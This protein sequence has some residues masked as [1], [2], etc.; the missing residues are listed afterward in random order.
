MCCSL[1]FVQKNNAHT[2]PDRHIWDDSGMKC[3]FGVSYILSMSFYWVIIVHIISDPVR[4]TTIQYIISPFSIVKRKQIFIL[5]FYQSTW[6]SCS[7]Q[8]VCRSALEKISPEKKYINCMFWTNTLNKFCSEW[9]R[10]D[11]F[12]D[13]SHSNW[14]SFS[15]SNRPSSSPFSFL[16]VFS[17]WNS[18]FSARECIH[19]YACLNV[20]IHQCQ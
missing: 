14:W 2:I 3:L 12:V 8:C 13:H 4:P 9:Q 17:D 1:A 11:H 5:I 20:N 6:M 7:F 15:V 16:Y 10:T 18:L 19:D